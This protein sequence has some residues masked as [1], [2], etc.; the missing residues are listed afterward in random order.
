VAS[1]FKQE[2]G[3]K[4]DIPSSAL[5]ENDRTEIWMTVGFVDAVE[6]GRLFAVLSAIWPLSFG[7]TLD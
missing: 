4:N 7:E 6:M 3:G 5:I 1:G 2:E